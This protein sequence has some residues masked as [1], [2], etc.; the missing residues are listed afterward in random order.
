M[1]MK[2]MAPTMSETLSLCHQIADA[3]TPTMK[4]WPRLTELKTYENPGGGGGGRRG[5]KSL[6]DSHWGQAVGLSIH[7]SQDR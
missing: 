6:L 7:L 4:I 1:D 2:N 5:S 3:I